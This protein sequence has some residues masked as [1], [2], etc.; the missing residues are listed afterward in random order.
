MGDVQLEYPSKLA[1]IS[2]DLTAPK[3]DVVFGS[4]LDASQYNDPVYKDEPPSVYSLD[5]E[6]LE[7]LLSVSEFCDRSC[8]AISEKFC[9]PTF[10][11][12]RK[13]DNG[14]CFLAQ[15]QLIQTLRC[16]LEAQWIAKGRINTDLPV[17]ALG[18]VNVGN[19]VEFWA[20][21]PN[22]EDDDQVSLLNIFPTHSSPE[23]HLCVAYF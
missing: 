12:E 15:N 18:I 11:I 6:R 4:R 22:D 20:A 14:S 2:K 5:S 9:F 16:M 3:P 19:W 13:S 23:W 21:W 10:A 1:A 7:S 17:L 8:G